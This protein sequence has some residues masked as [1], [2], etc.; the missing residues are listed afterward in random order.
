[1]WWL[2]DGCFVITFKATMIII[3][4]ADQPAG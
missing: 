4:H 1:M 2:P 3:I